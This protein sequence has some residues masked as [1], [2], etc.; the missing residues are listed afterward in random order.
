MSPDRKRAKTPQRS[1]GAPRKAKNNIKQVQASRLESQNAEEQLAQRNAELAIL[2][3]ISQAMAR[4]L[5]MDGIIRTVGDKVRDIFRA[6]VTEI[7]L[8][9]ES[10]GMIQPVYS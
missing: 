5:D 3:S 7:L 9:D 4:R 10:T 8:L 1:K 2:N 6:E